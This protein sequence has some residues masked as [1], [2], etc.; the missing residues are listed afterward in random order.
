MI[1]STLIGESKRCRP[2]LNATLDLWRGD[3]TY[4][5]GKKLILVVDR[6]EETS[7]SQRGEFC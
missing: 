3:E 4:V 2:H 5:K 7:L 6:Q 1:S